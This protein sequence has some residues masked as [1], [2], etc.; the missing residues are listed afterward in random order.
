MADHRQITER[1]GW[2]T[3]AINRVLQDYHAYA[4]ELTS[5]RGAP[6]CEHVSELVDVPRNVVDAARAAPTRVPACA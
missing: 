4:P 5:Y 1:L 3:R 6:L 2:S